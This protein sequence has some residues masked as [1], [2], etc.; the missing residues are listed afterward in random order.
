KYIQALGGQ[1][2]VDALTSYTAQGKSLL[3]GE[4]GAGNPAE[5]YAKTTGQ[6]ATFVHQQEGDVVRAYDGTAAW[7]QIPLTVTPQY[8][9]GATL[10]EGAKFDAMMAFPWRIRPFFTNWRVA[11]PDSIDGVDLD[12]I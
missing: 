1:A 12:V 10:L 5:I 3:F 8:Q 4:V 11:Y 2:R 7:W 9:L 6:M